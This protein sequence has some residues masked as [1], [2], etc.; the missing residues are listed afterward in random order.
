MH[1]IEY[2][3]KGKRGK[4]S[5]DEAGNLYYEDDFFNWVLDYFM[6][7]ID[8][9]QCFMSREDYEK[10]AAYEIICPDEQDI[11]DVSHVRRPYYR[12]RGKKVTRQQAFDIIRR[13]D[14][15]FRNSNKV[16]NHPEYVGNINFDNWLIEKNHYPSG[17]GWIHADG[18]VG[19][20]AITQKYPE[21]EEFVVE[22][23]LKLMAFPYLDLIIAITCWDEVPWE[24]MEDE[25]E[26]K[27]F[28]SP[29]YDEKFYDAVRLGI[30][31]HNQKIEILD[32]KST[33]KKYKEYEKQYGEGFEKYQSDYYMKREIEQVS[34]SDL[35]ACF[36]AY[37]L[38]AEEE[39]RQIPEYV[40]KKGLL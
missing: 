9:R 12:M 24:V 4:L 10:Y 40:W 11:K 7:S 28:Y 27:R 34:Q 30:Y 29:A 23:L 32:R 22:W 3:T 21:T 17:Y 16:T 6:L 13:T 37:G 20:N 26:R 36:A 38:D 2:L 25:N 14:N 15:F 33:L 8:D 19:A 39:L 35:E 31:V 18:T 1:I 5:L